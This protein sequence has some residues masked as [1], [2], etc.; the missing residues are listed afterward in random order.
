MIVN[1]RFRTKDELS[2]ADMFTKV[3]SKVSTIISYVR[4]SCQMKF[5]NHY[6]ESI[7]FELWSLMQ[8]II[9]NIVSGGKPANAMPNFQSGPESPHHVSNESPNIGKQIQML[10]SLIERLMM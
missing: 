8:L 4:K 2:N 6:A 1:N 5:T 9:N 7:I 3:I 10:R